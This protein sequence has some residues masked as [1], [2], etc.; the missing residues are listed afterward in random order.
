VGALS[1][2][3]VFIF[4]S[5]YIQN[6]GKLQKTYSAP[7]ADCASPHQPAKDLKCSK[8]LPIPTGKSNK[9]SIVL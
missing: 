8:K 1:Q 3:M 9:E 7:P 2:F 4:F 5:Q 6:S